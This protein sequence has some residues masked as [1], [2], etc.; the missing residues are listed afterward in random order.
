MLRRNVVCSR[1]SLLLYVYCPCWMSEETIAATLQSRN[2]S[3]NLF[4]F[5]VNVVIL[6]VFPP[7]IDLITF[8]AIHW[9]SVGFQFSR[10][11]FIRRWLTIL[12]LRNHNLRYTCSFIEI[13]W[14]LAWR[15]IKMAKG[16]QNLR[17]VTIIRF[18]VLF[19]LLCSTRKLIEI[20]TT[21]WNEIKDRIFLLRFLSTFAFNLQ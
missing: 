14:R 6:L 4:D 13:I 2:T 1:F 16:K 11:F 10:L 21:R 5:I 20:I 12:L 8:C 19:S 15:K 9:I 7:K 3:Y 17:I 18:D